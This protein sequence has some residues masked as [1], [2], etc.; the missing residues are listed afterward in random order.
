[1]TTSGIRIGTPAITTRGM[2]E[3]EMI[4]IAKFIN[5]ALI[6][7]APQLPIISFEA[8]FKVIGKNTK[9]SMNSAAIYGTSSM[10][11]GMIKKIKKELNNPS[12]KVI[13][14]GGLMS[15]ISSHCEEKID[16]IEPNL[17]LKGIY[18]IYIKNK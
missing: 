13:G 1:M 10:I 17:V 6:N 12:L 15:F 4:L 18:N 7:K 16:I 14:T 9:D 5:E 8:P 2:K 11:D 3:E